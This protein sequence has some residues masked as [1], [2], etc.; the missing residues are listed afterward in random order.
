[1]IRPSTLWILAAIITITAVVYQR[2]TGPTCPIE[3]KIDISGQAITYRMERSHGGKGDQRIAIT[4]TDPLIRGSLHH[5]RYR[6]PDSFTV[7]PMER[8]SDTLVGYL[9]HQPPGGKLEYYVELTYNDSSIIV[10]GRQTVV[11]R[12]RGA[13]PTFVLSL[14]ILFIFT[15][16]FLSTR[17]GLEAISPGGK[18]KYLTLW[19]TLLL[20][21]GGM[22][23]GPVVQ[24]YAFGAFWTGVPFGWDLTDNKTLIAF[25]CWVIALVRHKFNPFPRYWVIAAAI[26]LLVIYLIPHSM[27]GS[28]L[29]YATGEVKSG[30]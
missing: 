1:M 6:L 21:L 2:K 16:M 5:K 27:M 12:F 13:V 4:A 23:L 10:P 3:G 7:K 24:K 25:T 20:M 30:C 19:T 15:A 26:I 22:I 28:E 14:H 8:F 9:P 11:T 17:T 29:D 18:T